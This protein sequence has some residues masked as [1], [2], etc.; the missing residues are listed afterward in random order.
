MNHKELVERATKWLRNFFHC[1]VVLTELVA[2]T[3]SCE[4]PDAIGFI[5][6]KTILIECKTS[7]AD[8]YR[9]C[10]K[11][12]RHPLSP[13][14][15]NWRFYLTLPGLLKPEQIIQGWGLYEVHGRSIIHKSGVEYYNAGRPP[16][17]SDR[18]SEIAIL[19]SAFW[20]I[21]KKEKN[22]KNDKKKIW[23]LNGYKG[24][25]FY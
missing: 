25:W 18:N 8:F 7:K 19:V 14:L 17:E 2:N 15:G 10:K 24:I 23:V 11:K 1:R 12:A 5:A 22:D 9:D 16:F 20:K 4:T 21:G 6:G 13:A 3:D